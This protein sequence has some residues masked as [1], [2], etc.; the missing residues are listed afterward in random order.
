M[1]KMKLCAWCRK[2]PV[3]TN[4]NTF[5]SKACSARWRVHRYPPGPMS[6]ETKD[7]I[8]DRL[9]GA[10]KD[11]GLPEVREARRQRMAKK[12]PMKSAKTR[13][14]VSNTLREKGH[15]PRVRGGM[16]APLPEAHQRLADALGWRTEWP[17]ATGWGKG[18]HYVIDIVNPRTKIAVEV[19]G[20]SHGSLKKQASD[21]RKDA[22]LQEQGWL[23][24][25]VSNDQALQNT[26]KVA[27]SIASKSAARVPIC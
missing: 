9:R 7:K 21:R 25:R 15:K 10:Y 24:L 16:G 11:G 6:Q 8:A 18:H 22:F 1:P 26:A 4:R 13:A 23:V 19:D 14:K 2:T 27:A 3:K 5:C 20:S 12:N 17:I